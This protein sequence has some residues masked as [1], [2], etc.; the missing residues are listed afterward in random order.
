M[1]IGELPPFN[2]NGK[3]GATPY[4]LF[5]ENREMKNMTGFPFLLLISGV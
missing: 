4:F 1:E 3:T 2:R 5:S